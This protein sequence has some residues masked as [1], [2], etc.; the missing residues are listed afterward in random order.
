MIF[1]QPRPRELSRHD[2]LIIRLEIILLV[3]CL[4][5]NILLVT[6]PIHTMQTI[7]LV[8][9]IG[10]AG[11]GLGWSP[12]KDVVRIVSQYYLS[13]EDCSLCKRGQAGRTLL[14]VIYLL[15]VSLILLM[16][17]SFSQHLDNNQPVG[18]ITITIN[19]INPHLWSEWCPES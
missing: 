11:A 12:V 16:M 19:T 7:S 3:Y 13:C 8:W 15:I 14:I 1:V 10:Q 17:V 6:S 9:L 4:S 2:G 18:S 5:S